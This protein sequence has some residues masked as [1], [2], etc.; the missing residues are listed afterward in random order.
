MRRN[1][2]VGAVKMEIHRCVN[3]RLPAKLQLVPKTSD[4]HIGCFPEETHPLPSAGAYHRAT[5]TLNE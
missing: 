2:E 1:S 5:R 3:G 4:T